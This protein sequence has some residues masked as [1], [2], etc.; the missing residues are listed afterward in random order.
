ML[1]PRVGTRSR[2]NT[3]VATVMATMLVQATAPRTLHVLDL[4]PHGSEPHA[5][6][7]VA[8][9]PPGAAWRCSLR[10]AGVGVAVDRRLEPRRRWRPWGSLRCPRHSTWPKPSPCT[11]QRRCRYR[12]RSR[13]PP[14]QASSS[15]AASGLPLVVGSGCRTHNASWAGHGAVRVAPVLPAAAGRPPMAVA[16][17]REVR[18]PIAARAPPQATASSAHRRS[19]RWRGSENASTRPRVERPACGANACLPA[20]R[21]PSFAHV[22]MPAPTPPPVAPP[23]AR[24]TSER[25]LPVQRRTHD[26]GGGRVPHPHPGLLLGK[27]RWAP[28]FR[29]G[30]GVGATPCPGAVVVAVVR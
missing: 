23:V 13:P 21:L 7:H 3:P 19:V 6:R 4:R 8:H 20:L 2:L 5:A 11:V 17:V 27:W 29:R 22:A 28:S 25:W 26:G 15:L 16:L 14:T 12:S 10:V 24:P 1:L 30:P 18:V 9:I